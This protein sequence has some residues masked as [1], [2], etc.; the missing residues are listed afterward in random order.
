VRECAI[1]GNRFY[2]DN[3]YESG[4]AMN[5]IVSGTRDRQPMSLKELNKLGRTPSAETAIE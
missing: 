3:H 5:K 1:S 4:A 2:A